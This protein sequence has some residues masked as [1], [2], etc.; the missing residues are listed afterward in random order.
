MRLR[1]FRGVA[2]TG[3]RLA[4]EHLYEEPFAGA[5]SEVLRLKLRSIQRDYQRSI[6]MTPPQIMAKLTGFLRPFCEAIGQ[7]QSVETVVL[8]SLPAP[9]PHPTAEA[10]AN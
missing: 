8:D 6:T 5:E 4:W 1:G 7:G 10:G 3:F 2:P 9:A